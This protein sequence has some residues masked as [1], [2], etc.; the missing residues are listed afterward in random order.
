VLIS[1]V[2]EIKFIIT[3]PKNVNVPLD[4]NILMGIIALGVSFPNFGTQ[5]P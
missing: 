5:K 3:T 4:C 1:L 2:Q